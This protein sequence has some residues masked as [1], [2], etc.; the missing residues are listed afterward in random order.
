MELTAR[1]VILRVKGTMGSI[2]EKD[3]SAGIVSVQ[4]ANTILS[5]I[6]SQGFKIVT[7]NAFAFDAES[8]TLYVLL[9]KQ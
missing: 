8:Y 2:S 7:A 9:A 4:E 6:M 5:E 3:L 1:N